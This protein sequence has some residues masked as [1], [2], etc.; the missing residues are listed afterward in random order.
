M[1]LSSSAHSIERRGHRGVCPSISY[2]PSISSD[3]LNR[4]TSAS[5]AGGDTDFDATPDILRCYDGKTYSAGACTGSESAP[6]KGRLSAVGSS[7]SLSTLAYDPLGR[8]SSSAQTTA[9]QLYPF[10]YSYN[11][12]SSLRQQTYPSGRRVD[13]EY[14]PAGR[15]TTATGTFESP[16]APRR[17]AAI[18]SPGRRVRGPNPTLPPANEFLSRPLTVGALALGEKDGKADGLSFSRWRIAQHT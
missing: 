13:F 4:P 16:F 7:V 14:D 18:T 17:A 2:C 5:Y 15:P 3:E 9:G 12:D 6:N 10:T 1:H 11:A 8:V